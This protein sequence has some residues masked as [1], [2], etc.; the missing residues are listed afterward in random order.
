MELRVQEERVGAF[1]LPEEAVEQP[2]GA[3]VVEAA[4]GPLG[5]AEETFWVAL[6]GEA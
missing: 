6:V 5:E 2:D 1:W 4:K 3:V